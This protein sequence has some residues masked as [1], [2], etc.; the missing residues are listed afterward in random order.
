MKNRKSAFLHTNV[1]AVDYTNPKLF[2]QAFLAFGQKTLT[3]I[4]SFLYLKI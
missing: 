4:F 1:L 2:A 3:K